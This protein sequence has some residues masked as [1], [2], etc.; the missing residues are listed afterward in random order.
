MQIRVNFF[1]GICTKVLKNIFYVKLSIHDFKEYF[2][3]CDRKKNVSKK[4]R[5]KQ[6]F[7]GKIFFYSVMKIINIVMREDTTFHNFSC[8][9]LSQL[10]FCM[11]ILKNVSSLFYMK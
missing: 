4:V 8:S 11:I 2:F 10:C 7:K 6:I 9:K 3:S 5:G 1:K